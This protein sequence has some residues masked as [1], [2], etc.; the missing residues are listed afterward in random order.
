MRS[1]TTGSGAPK[2]SALLPTN[3]SAKLLFALLPRRD[4]LQRRACRLGLAAVGQKH[5]PIIGLM[6]EL[7]ELN[8]R[9]G[10]DKSITVF[11]TKLCVGPAHNC[12]ILTIPR[13]KC[14]VILERQPTF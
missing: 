14:H 12:G 13:H 6:F 3:P 11:R 9:S 4:I 5:L 10:K 7:I 8:T 1:T 2:T